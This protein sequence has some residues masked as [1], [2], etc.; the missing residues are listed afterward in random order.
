MPKPST[1]PSGYLL[2]NNPENA[3][4]ILASNLVVI[5]LSTTL[6]YT[7]KPSIETSGYQLVDNPGMHAKS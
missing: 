4:K 2:V 3:R 1:E 5:Y 6:K 7:P